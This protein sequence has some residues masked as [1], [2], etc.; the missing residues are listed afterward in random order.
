MEGRGW[1]CEVL[2]GPFFQP[3]SEQ[4]SFRAAMLASGYA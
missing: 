4:A 3:R 2:Y 1:I